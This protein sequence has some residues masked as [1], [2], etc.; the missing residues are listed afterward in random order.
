MILNILKRYLI[1]NVKEYDFLTI[2]A[3]CIIAFLLVL[4]IDFICTIKKKKK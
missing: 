3:V 1:N 4:G 2:I